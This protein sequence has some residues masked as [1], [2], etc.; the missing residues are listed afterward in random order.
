MNVVLWIA[1]ILLAGTFF[2]TGFSKL[3]AYDKLV[4]AVEARSRTHQKVAMTRAQA[5]V[6]GLLEIAGACCLLI[7]VDVIP[8]YVLL[9]GTAAVL[10]VM[11]VFAGIYN[12]R[13]QEPAAPSVVLFLL[14]LL[15]IVGRWPR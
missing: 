6:L 13:R 7:P 3:L 8:P 15:I 4:R 12:I 1:Q 5:A 11:M 14:S 2:F 10:A 9:R